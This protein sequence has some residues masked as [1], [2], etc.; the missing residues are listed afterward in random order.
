MIS[1]LPFG[2]AEQKNEIKNFS[3]E[4]FEISIFANNFN[5]EFLAPKAAQKVVM[6]VHVSD[7]PLVRYSVS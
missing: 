3:K 2:A 4:I 1:A 5:N 7:S 6:Y